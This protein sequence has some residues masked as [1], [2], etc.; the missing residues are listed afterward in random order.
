MGLSNSPWE[1]GCFG[2]TEQRGRSLASLCI[3]GLL[4]DLARQ[5]GLGKLRHNLGA[6]GLEEALTLCPCPFSGPKSYRTALCPC[7]PYIPLAGQDSV[8]IASHLNITCPPQPPPPSLSAPRWPQ[9]K[10]GPSLTPLFRSCLPA[11]SG[12][13][14]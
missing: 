5:G 14:P 12:S 7:P 11:L 9:Y 3:Q 2:S 1:N 4:L 6:P 10:A 8:S 13:H